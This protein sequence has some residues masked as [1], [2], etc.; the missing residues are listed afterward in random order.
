MGTRVSNVFNKVKEHGVSLSSVMPTMFGYMSNYARP[1]NN[2][3]KYTPKKY[4]KILRNKY[5][6]RVYYRPSANPFIRPVAK[7][8]RPTA[9]AYKYR[10][11]N[12]VTQHKYKSI[13]GRGY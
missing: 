13:Y 1:E 12:L 3:R 9:Y 10:N 8:Y 6:P 11:N 2:Y 7:Q 4:N 5:Y